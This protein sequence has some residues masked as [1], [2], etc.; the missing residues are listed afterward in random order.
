MA[1][2]REL[3]RSL[4]FIGQTISVSAQAAPVC[5]LSTLNSSYGAQSTGTVVSLI[6]LFTASIFGFLDLVVFDGIA[7]DIHD[8]T[9]DIKTTPIVSP[10]STARSV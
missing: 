1:V 5:K 10:T 6:A 2:I 9:V 7:P 3:L 8:K 4:N